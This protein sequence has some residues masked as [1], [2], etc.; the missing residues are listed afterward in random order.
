MRSATFAA[1]SD[2]SASAS[3]KEFVCSDCAPPHAA[4]SAWIATRTMLFSGCCAVSVEPPVWAWKRSASAFGF[5][6]AEALAHHPRPEPPGRAELRHFLEEV[7]VR[8]EEEGEACCE[9]V[10]RQPRRHGRI[11]VRDPVRE[12]E[13][14]LLDRGR[15]GLADV[16]S[17][18]RD[19]VPAR[20]PLGAVGEQIGGQP[21]RG[22]R[23]EDVV[24]AG[25][26]LLQDVVLDGAAQ[27]GRIDSLRLGD[28]FV[29]QQ[30]Q[31][32]RRVDRHRRRDP[33]ERDPVEEH[34]H[35]G[36]RVDRHAGA[37]HLAFGARVVGVVAELRRQVE[38][39]RKPGLAVLEQVAEARVRLPRGGKP[40]VLADRPG[41]AAVH[42]LVRAARKRRGTRLLE[43][44]RR[45]LGRVD[46]LDLD[47]GV[48]LAPIDGGHG[49]RLLR[50]A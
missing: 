44:A 46:R 32:R 28:Q 5:V 21:H 4:A 47:S 50:C 27:G 34:L 45:I 13:R 48:G 33:V 35:V 6:D 3:S 1:A 23:R 26:V 7:V 40:R 17:R 31:G 38:R 20:E 8:V 16:V 12:R 30:Q 42:V 24:P 22:P 14:E 10:G 43:L 29:E 11:A 39:H 49:S 15:A 36:E 9:L 41:P 25:D 18:D 19:R 2:G 37:A